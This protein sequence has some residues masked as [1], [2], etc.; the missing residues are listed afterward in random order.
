LFVLRRTRPDVERPYRAMVTPVLPA[1]Y[2]VMAL[3]IDVV[4]LRYNRSFTWPGLIIVLLGIPV[5]F[6]WRAK[7]ALKQALQLS[8]AGE[9]KR[10]ANIWARKPMNMLLAEAGETGERSLK[11][12]LGPFQLTALGVGAVIGA[13][14]LCSPV[15]RALCRTGSHAF[16]CRVRPGMRLRG[17]LLCRVCRHDPLA[18]SATPMLTP[19]WRTV[20]LDH[21]LGPYSGIRHG[22]QHRVVGLSNHFIELLDIFHIK[23]PLWLAYDHW[24]GLRAAE[25]IVARQMAQASTLSLLP[26]L[27]PSSTKFRTS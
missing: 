17:A 1:I 11:R 3:F 18:G 14:I 21:R 10:M 16:V 8:C 2:I 24:T 4:L 23:M 27:R 20:C 6:L 19:L 12:T 5:Y 26:A 7:C 22:R 25:N 13:G 15:G 9:S